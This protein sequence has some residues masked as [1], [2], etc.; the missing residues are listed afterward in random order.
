MR[1]TVD[2]SP[3][4]HGIEQDQT[5]PAD[6]WACRTHE[7]LWNTVQSVLENVTATNAVNFFVHR[8]YRALAVK[9]L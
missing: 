6:P 7:A 4:E 8:G 1:A 2:S 5:E 9:P 3:I